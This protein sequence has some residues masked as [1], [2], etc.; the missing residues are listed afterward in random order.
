MT[1]YRGRHRAR[2]AGIIGGALIIIAGLGA[3]AALTLSGSGPATAAPVAT[4]T[5]T[6]ATVVSGID[7]SQFT[8]V[9]SWPDV[10]AAGKSF[11]GIEAAQGKTVVNAHY[12]SQV[13]GALAAGLRVMP[14]VFANPGRFATDPTFTGAQQFATAWTVINGVSGQPY[15]FGSKWLPITLD[16]EWDHTNYPT[17]E[18]YGLST[19][20]MVSW[21][22]S[23]IGAAKS[24]TGVAP[25]IYTSQLWWQDCTGNIA[26]FTADPLWVTAWGVSSP[27]L[28]VG[29]QAYTFWQSSSTGTVSGVT[30]S[31]DL[32]QMKGITVSAASR[33]TVTGAPESVQVATSGPDQSAGYQPALH[34]TGVPAGMSM[35]SN[36]L[37][38]G[39]PAAAG[40]YPVTVTA[41][42]ALGGTGGGSF[43]WTVSSAADSGITGSVSQ[44]GG[45]DKC[46]DDPSSRTTAGTA[47][48]L[49][50]CTGKANQAWTSVQDG[51][52]RVLGHCLAASGTNV[53]LYPCDGSIA[54]QWRAGTYGSLIDIRYGT[55]LN[56]PSGAVANGTKPTL[57]TC[58]NTASKV[59]QHWTRPAGPVVSGIGGKCL[60]LSGSTAVLV[61]CANSTA[62]HWTPEPAGTFALQSN[63]WCLAEHTTAG[64]LMSIVR[65]SNTTP[66]QQWT[67]AAA[68]NIAVE[69]KNPATGLCITV[70]SGG[71]TG[72][73]LVLGTCSTALSSTWRVG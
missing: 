11:V 50:T 4:A 47:I 25:V 44:H 73:K 24:Q 46:L 61:T 9:T 59:N 60:G 45:S 66:T 22:Q 51:S 33:T 68:G 15:S 63:G 8:D 31:V 29:W 58:Q 65:C 32:D 40:S 28:P 20:N 2:Q 16:L 54:D 17:K 42:D 38:T 14:Y 30:G 6:A 49:A 43:T 64:S 26:Q 37:I 69:L 35:S 10:K 36:G 13:T 52:I 19:A 3:T 53:L 62:Q 27:P 67:L 55:C 5:T 70:P 41:S 18:C 12:A 57:V 72:T 56:G 7:V 39:W 1:G 21:I 48:D 34:A 71:T 23:F